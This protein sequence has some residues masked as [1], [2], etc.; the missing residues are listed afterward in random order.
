MI[1]LPRDVG[2]LGAAL[3]HRSAQFNSI[4]NAKTGSETGFT[5]SA[6]NGGG[7][8]RVRLFKLI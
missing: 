3:L 5:K 8:E 7:K 6:Q 2:V 4:F 1:I